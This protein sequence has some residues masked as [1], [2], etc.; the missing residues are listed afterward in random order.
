M[1]FDIPE[2]NN[3]SGWASL[4]REAWKDPNCSAMEGEVEGPGKGWRKRKEWESQGLQGWGETW[5]RRQTQWGV[6]KGVGQFHVYNFSKSEIKTLEW[7][8]EEMPYYYLSE[9]NT[10]SNPVFRLHHTKGW[11]PFWASPHPVLEPGS[12]SRGRPSWER[13][14]PQKGREVGKAQEEASL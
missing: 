4:D 12:L 1:A 2:V 3:R 10:G 9:A 11:P 13:V 5:E 8:F 14:V 7:P 6:F